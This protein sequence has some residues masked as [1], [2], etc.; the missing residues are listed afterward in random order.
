MCLLRLDL[1]DVGG[2]AR[3][4]DIQKYIHM[5][6]SEPRNAVS[7]CMQGLDAVHLG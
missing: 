1:T 5:L 3:G 7:V 4:D 2:G 6:G